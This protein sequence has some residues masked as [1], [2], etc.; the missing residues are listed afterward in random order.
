M[1]FCFGHGTDGR[2]HVQDDGA[3]LIDLRRDVERDAREERLQPQRRRVHR[4]AAVVVELV[5]T[6][7]T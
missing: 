6:P 5:V 1:F 4:A 3:G 2:V 7:V